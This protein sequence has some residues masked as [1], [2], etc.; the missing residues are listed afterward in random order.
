MMQG[1]AERMHEMLL[2]LADFSYH[3]GELRKLERRN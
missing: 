3:E 2:A 1:A